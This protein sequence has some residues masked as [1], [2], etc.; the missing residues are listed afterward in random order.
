MQWQTVIQQPNP[1]A[2]STHPQQWAV[3][4]THT[5]AVSGW[6]TFLAAIF[7]VFIWLWHV[8]EVFIFEFIRLIKLAPAERKQT[9]RSNIFPNWPARGDEVG[10]CVLYL[11]KWLWR[12][13]WR[14]GVGGYLLSLRWFVRWRF[15]SSWM[16]VM[17]LS[18]CIAQLFM[19]NIT[20]I[21]TV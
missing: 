6:G 13:A 18:T 21:D 19:F 5:V 12:E 2:Q 14:K 1:V 8:T 20:V 11:Q 17:D 3:T 15:T 7:L 10:S 4:A 9:S 16:W